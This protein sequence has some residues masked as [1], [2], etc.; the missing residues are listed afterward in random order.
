[1]HL[2]FVTV[3]GRLHRGGGRFGSKRSAKG[4]V[5]EERLHEFFGGRCGVGMMGRRLMVVVARLSVAGV[6]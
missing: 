1:M 6:G 3:V 2:I 4:S 5:I